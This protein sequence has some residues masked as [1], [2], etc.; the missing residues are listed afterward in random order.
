MAGRVEGHHAKT[1]RQQRAAEIDEPG[2]ATAPAVDQQ[3]SGAALPPRPRCH[4][5][6]ADFHVEPAAPVQPYRHALADR[7][8]WRRAKQPLG[9]ACGE[10]GGGA[11]H[12]D[13]SG[14][15][16][17]EGRAHCCSYRDITQSA[18]ARVHESR[19]VTA[20]YK[21]PP[22]ADGRVAVTLGAERPAAVTTSGSW[23]AEIG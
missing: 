2:T 8:T 18:L 1:A 5:P 12:G 13:E 3:H 22:Y 9:P 17:A 20:T 14:A 4:S 10:A 21:D 23:A 19:F 15:C 11:L 6:A 16:Q 7:A